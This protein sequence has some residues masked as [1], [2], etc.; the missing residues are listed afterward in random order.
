MSEVGKNKPVTPPLAVSGP[1]KV[2]NVTTSPAEA[3]HEVAKA[4]LPPNVQRA[5]SR[6]PLTK[7]DDSVGRAS[8][9]DTILEKGFGIFSGDDGGTIA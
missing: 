5:F 6:F 9:E 1:N 7:R 2:N 3:A 8:K 4:A